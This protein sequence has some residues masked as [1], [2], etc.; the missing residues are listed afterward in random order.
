MTAH[1]TP[2]IQRGVE[3]TVPLN[4]MKSSPK[5]ARRTPHA[6]ADIETLAA[7]IAAK[8]ILQPPV[9][10]REL[11][12]EGKETGFYLVTIGEG[13]RL[14]LA[15]LAKRKVIAKAEP[16]RCLLDEDNDAFEVSLDENVTRFA[17]HPADQFEAFRELSERNG[18]SA[19]AI[20]TRF[21]VGVQVVRQR[22]RLGAVSPALLAAYRAGDLTLDQLM[23]FAV[24]EDHDRQQQVYESLSYNRSPA[25]IRR[26]MTEHEVEASDRRAVF[27]G[28]EAY[29]GAGGRVRRDLFAEDRGGWFEDVVLL[30]RLV[31]EKLAAEAEAVRAKEGWLW[32]EAHLDYPHAHGLRR[33]YAQPVEHDEAESAR[34]SALGE[35]YDAIVAPCEDDEPLPEAAEARVRQIEAELEAASQ[36]VYDPEVRARAG[37]FL[38]L[39]WDG[40]M[41]IERGFVRPADETPAPQ[42][43]EGGG[44]GAGEEPEEAHAE[45]ASGK[46]LSERLIAE[47]T[48]QR[49]AALRDSLAQH[50]ALA[51]VAA[52]HALVLQAFYTGRE[53]S[54]LELRGPA[55]SLHGFIEAVGETPAGQAIDARHGAW[56]ARLPEDPSA[57]W[58]YVLSLTDDEKGA[59][60][61]HCVSLTVNAVKVVGRPRRALA[62]A[63][64]LASSLALD[65]TGYPKT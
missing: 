38:V 17:M 19:E 29:E 51:L 9:V 6:S 58:D 34:L 3:I 20:A 15:L 60:F 61:A 23:A 22:L 13:R 14:A 42:P 53:D 44:D 43:D 4:K 35:E 8:G 64:Q 27:V 54:C 37:L 5:N 26:M 39:S 63:E 57:A 31:V 50:P 25:L 65:M 59:L 49:T 30:D 24:C 45:T 56:A 41:R 32:A 16:V 28:V 1:E 7:S 52:L 47:L 11:T 10:E 33:V 36:P 18:W 12:G 2:V 46:P 48:A 55:T 21:G 40:S 62:H